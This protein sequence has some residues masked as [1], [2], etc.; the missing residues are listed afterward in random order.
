MGFFLPKIQNT[1]IFTRLR[2]KEHNI[3]ENESI[4]PKYTT[5]YR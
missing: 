5:F 3:T 2:R 4:P 1:Y